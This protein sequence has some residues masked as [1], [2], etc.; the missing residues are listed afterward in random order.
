M[1]NSAKPNKAAASGP[2]RLDRLIGPGVELVGLLIG[3][4]L[5]LRVGHWH[6]TVSVFFLLL[7]W[8]SVVLTA[9]YLWEAATAVA[10]PHGSFGAAGGRREDLLLEK[11]HLLKAIKELEFDHEMGK[12]SDADA[13]EITRL[14]R[15][16]AIEVIKALE[17]KQPESAQAPDKEAVR[18]EIE[19]EIERRL[20][21]Q[22]ADQKEVEP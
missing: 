12:M 14:Y 11:R 20:A 9:R 13:T 5:I 15:S 2:S 3:W 22:K 21:D 8:A 6:L 4:L 10:E 1:T 16:R 7:G 17:G 19:H 18:Q